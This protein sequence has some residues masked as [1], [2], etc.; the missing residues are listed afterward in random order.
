MNF[1]RILA[2]QIP[3]YGSVTFQRKLKLRDRNCINVILL[4][5]TFIFLIKLKF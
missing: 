3:D 4:L 5:N 1:K 2:L